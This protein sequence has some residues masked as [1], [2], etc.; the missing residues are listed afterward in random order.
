MVNFLVV[1]VSNAPELH[2]YTARRF[3]SSFKEWKGQ[4]RDPLPC[5]RRVA[6][7]PWSWASTPTRGTTCITWGAALSQGLGLQASAFW[8]LVAPFCS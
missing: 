2:G 7:S 1:A 8:L 6:P 3:Y 5:R 4:V